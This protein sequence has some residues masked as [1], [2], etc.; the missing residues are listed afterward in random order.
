MG[1]SRR[2]VI[3]AGA[4][5][6]AGALL[7]LDTLLAA[8]RPP[9]GRKRPPQLGDTLPWLS[10]PLLQSHLNEIFQVYTPSEGWIGM[11]LVR[12]EDVPSAVASGLVGSPDCFTA[13]F[14][15]PRF[16]NLKQGTYNVHNRAT[17]M[18]TLFLVP[19]GETRTGRLHTAT[20]NRAQG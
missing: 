3:R 18:F 4:L 16:A 17:G 1:T 13:I 11:R 9:L 7:P 2:D 10:R 12:V 19:G 20:I 8:V 15:S 5:A 6:G 14:Q